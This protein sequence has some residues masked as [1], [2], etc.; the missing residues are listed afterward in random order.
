VIIDIEGQWESGGTTTAGV[1][2]ITAVTASYLTTFNLVLH[3]QG[4]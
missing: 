3:A 1:H 4:L 2:P